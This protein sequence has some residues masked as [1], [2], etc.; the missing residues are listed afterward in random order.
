MSAK[1]EVIVVES[2][3]VDNLEGMGEP[4]PTKSEAEQLETSGLQASGP[5]KKSEKRRRRRSRDNLHPNQVVEWF[6]ACA[7]CSFF[8]AGYQVEQGLASLQESSRNSYDGWL[9]LDWSQGVRSLIVQSFACRVDI[10]CY[11]FDGVCPECQRRFAFST[12]PDLDPVNQ[13]RIE[14]KPRTG[15]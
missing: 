4:V 8:L 15:R 10:D 9:Y 6:S 11:H 12:Y 3:E 1:N 13:F 14:L 7:R 5:G 2:T